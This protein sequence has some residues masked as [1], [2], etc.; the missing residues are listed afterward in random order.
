MKKTLNNFHY[1][2]FALAAVCMISSCKKSTVVD[3]GI[4]ESNLDATFKVTSVAGSANKFL[5]TANNSSYI[6]SKWDLGTGA[7]P[8]IGKQEQEIF[9]PDAGTYII[10]HHAF[11]KGGNSFTATQTIVVATSDPVAGNLVQGGKFANATDHSKWTI[12]NIGG[13]NGG[14]VFGSGSVV[15]STFGNWSQQ[16]IYQAI[17]VV[18]GKAYKIDMI[19]SSPLGL[20]DTWFEVFANSAVPVQGNDYAFGGQVRGINTWT[21]CGLSAFSGL[22]STV[23]CLGSATVTFP[24][25]GT[26]YLVIKMG[27]GTSRSV[28]VK[29]VE[30][31]GT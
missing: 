11:G 26:I 4:T 6:L 3:R 7:G 15:C 29:N 25:S 19:V 12:L 1:L 31:R 13:N 5:L 22:I 24:T 17:N 27:G 2:L 20:V 23:G 8:A 30:M 18:G 9:L 21:G 14:W 10:T 28:T 16:G